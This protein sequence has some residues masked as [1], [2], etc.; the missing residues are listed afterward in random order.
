MLWGYFSEAGTGGLVAGEG[1]QN[2]VKYRDILNENLVQSAQA[3]RLAG[4]FTFQKDSDPKYTTKTM[5][6]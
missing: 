5:Q 3:L 2:G 4:T 1:K 6:G